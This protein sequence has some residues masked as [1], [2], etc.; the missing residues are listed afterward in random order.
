MNYRFKLTVC[1]LANIQLKGIQYKGNN[2]AINTLKQAS[3]QFI[4]CVITVFTSIKYTF[5][6]NRE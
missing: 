5:S 2:R 1:D 3:N 4:Q 6:F